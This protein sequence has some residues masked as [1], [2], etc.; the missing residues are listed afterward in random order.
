MVW[1]MVA[2]VHISVKTLMKTYENH[3]RKYVQRVVV[4]VLV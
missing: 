2:H 1:H 3:E 4:A